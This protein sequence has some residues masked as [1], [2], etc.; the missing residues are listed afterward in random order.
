MKHFYMNSK[1]RTSTYPV[2]AV[3]GMV[4]LLLLVSEAK[5]QVEPMA[6][7]PGP[8]DKQVP[9]VRTFPV[10]AFARKLSVQLFAGPGIQLPA[11]GA[12][13]NMRRSNAA[14]RSTGAEGLEVKSRLLPALQY[15]VGVGIRYPFREKILLGTGLQFVNL[16]YTNTVTITAKDSDYQFDRLQKIS[17]R[18]RVNAWQVPLLVQYLP[19]EKLVLEGGILVGFSQKKRAAVK[20][21]T[22]HEVYINGEV[23]PDYSLAPETISIPLAESISGVFPGLTLG[24]GYSLYKNF[25]LKSALQVVGPYAV[26]TDGRLSG[27]NLQ[28]LLT[29]NLK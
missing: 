12:A 8:P 29:Y 3:L 4:I 17:E 21:K 27:V 14:L 15:T 9:T 24:A 19:N 23:D 18:L 28:V 5:G 11:G 6:P 16:G 10:I 20:V 13:G 7:A 2:P 22:V 26:T 25:Y 1:T